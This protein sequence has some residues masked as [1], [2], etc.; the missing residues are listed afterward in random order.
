MLVALFIHKYTTY[1][2]RM[3]GYQT[4]IP[5]Y[6]QKAQDVYNVDTIYPK[7]QFSIRS[8]MTH[9]PQ[10]S[11]QKKP[12]LSI[13]IN[14]LPPITPPITPR[15]KKLAATFS[16]SVAGAIVIID[17]WPGAV[18]PALLSPWLVPPVLFVRGGATT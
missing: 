2:F 8:A 6:L 17:V 14:T 16:P 4:P 9:D 12:Q 18:I 13:T 10:K 1:V 3:F 11:N 15:V 7:R 5:A